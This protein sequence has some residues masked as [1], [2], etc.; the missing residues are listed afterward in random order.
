M[1]RTAMI[2]LALGTATLSGCGG[3]KLDKDSASKFWVGYI[4][5]V[6]CSEMSADEVADK[7]AATDDD[8][9]QIASLYQQEHDGLPSI[10]NEQTIC[11]KWDS[12]WKQ[13]TLDTTNMVKD[14]DGYRDQYDVQGQTTSRDELVVMK[15]GKLKISFQ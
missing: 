12:E 14:G 15:D 5:D 1:T 7:Y 10:V 3:T 9:A 8:K 6:D 13:K 4:H 2:V 11:P